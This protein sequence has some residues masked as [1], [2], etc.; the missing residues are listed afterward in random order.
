MDKPSHPQLEITNEKPPI[1]NMLNTN[2]ESKMNILSFNCK[3]IKTSGPFL[4][5]VKKN[6]DIILIQEHWLFEYE[7]HLLN[8][9]HE[10]YTGVGKAIDSD[11]NKDINYLKRGYGGVAI[12]WSRNID[13]YIKPKSEGNERIQCIEIN[14]DKPVLLISVYLPTKMKNRRGYKATFEEVERGGATGSGPDP[15]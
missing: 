4:E 9:L 8:E 11:L 10:Q 2:S 12:L 1:S 15:K 3:N 7:L 14:I 5:E 6:A 13:Q